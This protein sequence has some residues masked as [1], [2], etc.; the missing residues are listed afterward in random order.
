MRVRC[1]LRKCPKGQFSKF[2]SPKLAFALNLQS[3]GDINFVVK[4]YDIMK[5]SAFGNGGG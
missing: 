3:S 2:V 1:L 4:H 5:S